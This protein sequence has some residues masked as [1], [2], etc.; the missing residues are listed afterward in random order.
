MSSIKL[1]GSTSGE[2][3]ISAPAVAGT[4]TL[5]LPASTG[6]VAQTT[7]GLIEVDMYRL[8]ADI[9]VNSDPISS[10]LERC[11]DASFAKI[12]TGMS[13]SS[14]LFTFP[15]TGL[16][17][18]KV[19][20]TFNTVADTDNAV[21]QTYVTQDNGSNFDEVSRLAGSDPQTTCFSN[22][23]VNVTDTS[24]VKVKFRVNS[25]ASGGALMGD[26]DYNTTAFTFIRLG[27]SQ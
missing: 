17:E 13:V 20:A 22:A 21:V 8:N 14:G 12:G 15:R 5:T 4:N 1:Q 23:F 9:T 2:I 7:T 27:D 26:T 6:T 3:T 25:L 16:Y 11:D 24:N 10:N 19:M 18:V